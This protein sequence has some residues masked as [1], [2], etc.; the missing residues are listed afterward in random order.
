LNDIQLLLDKKLDRAEKLLTI[1]NNENQF[2]RTK[3]N[4]IMTVLRQM[5]DKHEETALKQILIIETEQK[6]QIEKYRMPL[7]Y[8]PKDLNMQK[9]TFKMLLETKD[10]TKLLRAKQNFDTYVN[11]TNKLLKELKMPSRTFY[12]LQVPN[13]LQKFEQYILG[14]IHY[15]EHSNG[16]LE[17]IIADNE[18]KQELLLISKHLTAMDMKIVSN[19]LQENMV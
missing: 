8:G 14:S 12:Q 15:T 1:I 5:I 16:Q 7:K 13:Q 3:I 10:N 17:N 19:A 6:N 2:N 18:T 11:K 9:A 4:E